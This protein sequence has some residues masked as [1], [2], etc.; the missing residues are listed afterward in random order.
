VRS[1]D[2]HDIDNIWERPASQES[3]YVEKALGLAL[4]LVLAVSLRGTAAGVSGRCTALVQAILLGSSFWLAKRGPDH[5]GEL[6]RCNVDAG[7]VVVLPS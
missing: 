6:D 2:T 5:P 7:D 3:S 1:V 4:L